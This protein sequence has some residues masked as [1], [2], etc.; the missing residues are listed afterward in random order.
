MKDKGK[1]LQGNGHAMYMEQKSV[2]TV[3]SKIPNR[4]E[5]NTDNSG[6]IQEK[7][8]GTKSHMLTCSILSNLVQ[9]KNFEWALP[10]V[11][12]KNT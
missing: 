3:K 10:D 6:P 5:F 7:I 9:I 4:M 11:E 12:T 8:G 1:D 2:I